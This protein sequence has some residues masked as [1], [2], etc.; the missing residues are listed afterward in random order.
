MHVS[1][2]RSPISVNLISA[3]REFLKS[4]ALISSAS[5]RFGKG[6]NDVIPTAKSLCKRE[7]RHDGGLELMKHE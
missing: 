6:I 4:V 5:W 2:G 3:Y 7:G 1:L